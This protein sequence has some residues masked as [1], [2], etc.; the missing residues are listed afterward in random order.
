MQGSSQPKPALDLPAGTAV[1]AH[2]RLLGERLDLRGLEPAQPLSAAPL[3]IRAGVSG[4][5]VLFRYG[6]VVS[7][8]LDD[9]EE[10]NLIASLRGRIAD[11]IEP[12]EDER[13]QIIVVRE[14][15][16]QVD[17]SGRIVVRELNPARMQIIADIL[18]KHLV[19]SHYEARIAT[20]FDRLEPLAS[21][22]RRTGRT[23]SQA[24]VL[25]QHIGGV[26]LIQHKMVGRVEVAEHPEVLWENPDL[27][28][29]YARLE[30]E[31]EL[32][33]RSR[34]LDRKLDFIFRAAETLLRLVESR[35]TMRL[36]WYVI[37]LIVLE[38]LLSLYG[39][40]VAA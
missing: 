35:R 5:A 21:A 15:D 1:V 39:I 8:N 23:G 20:V 30:T 6:V 9:A 3:T 12:P 11:P 34:A 25:L 10:A 13:F 37:A 26:L 33:D 28:R 29:F 24:D 2:A 38:V 19:L 31:Y 17:A 18:A 14:S 16:D 4:H 7:F 40:I 32:R 36:E 22:L 27:E